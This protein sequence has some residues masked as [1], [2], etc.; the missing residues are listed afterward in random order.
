MKTVQTAL[1]S[2]AILEYL[3][4]RPR[5]QRWADWARGRRRLIT[6][7]GDRTHPLLVVAHSFR[8]AR[9]ARQ[10]S[11]AVEQDW[12]EA[13]QRSRDAYDE[14]LFKAPGLI[15]LQLR[16]D[17]VCGCL[18][19]RHPIVRE[20]PF[21]EPHEVFAGA[22]TGEMDIA[23]RR[24]AAWQPLPLTDTAL[25]ARFLEGSRLNEFH[26][27]QFRLK[28]LSIIL[29]ETNHLTYPDAPEA[30]IRER[31]LAFY[32]EALASYVENAVATLSLTIDRSFSRLG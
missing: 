18:G 8:D 7:F 27:K 13:P 19:H 25:D 14:V 6:R 30:E 5:P 28:L 2:A 26:Q 3:H 11:L 24:V 32:H 21:A 9:T 12:L 22:R 31:S 16:R 23:W 29:H 4:S 15:V 20:A 1:S 10:L 17:N